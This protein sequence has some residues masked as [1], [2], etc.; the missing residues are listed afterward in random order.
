MYAY[1]VKKGSEISQILN[2]PWAGIIKFFPP[3][4]SLVSDIPAEDGNGANLL[5]SVK[6]IN[7]EFITI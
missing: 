7:C 2:S 1:T 3:R 4:E 5:Y 6:Y